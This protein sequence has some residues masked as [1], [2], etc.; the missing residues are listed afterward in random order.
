VA[1]FAWNDGAPGSLVSSFPAP[2]NRFQNALPT[3][4]VVGARHHTLGDGAPHVYD[5][6]TDYFCSLEL[7]GVAPAALANA[8]WLQRHL[9]RGGSVDVYTQNAAATV[10]NAATLAEGADVEIAREP[11]DY[12]FRVRVTLRNA[13]GTDFLVL[14]P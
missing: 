11:D 9:R 10:Y 6:R 7:P 13:A 5:Y 4:V 14:Y 12:L 1:Y 3:C 2:G 8:L